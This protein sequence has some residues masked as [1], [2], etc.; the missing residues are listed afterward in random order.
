VLAEVAEDL[1]HVAGRALGTGVESARSS[2]T[3]SSRAPDGRPI[4]GAL[5]RSYSRSE[6]RGRSGRGP[7]QA[8]RAREA[9]I[10]ALTW[11]MASSGSDGGGGFLSTIRH[12]GPD[13]RAPQARALAASGSRARTAHRSRPAGPGLRPITSS[14][15]SSSPLQMGGRVRHAGGVPGAAVVPGNQVDILLNGESS[16]PS[17]RP[18]APTGPSLRYVFEE[19][20]P[21]RPPP[22][23]RGP[24]SPGG[25]R[26]ARRGGLARIPPVP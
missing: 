26:A 4:A 22:G 20:R 24:A 21:P 13:R 16:R 11:L 6:V 19:G 5:T 12:R 1:G 10:N 8:D 25:A 17:S 2:S 23:P 9:M 7:A 18:S 3:R 14:P 15:T